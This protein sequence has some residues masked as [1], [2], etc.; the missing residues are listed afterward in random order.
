MNKFRNEYN[1]KI[2]LPQCPSCKKN[3]YCNTLYK[4]V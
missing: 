2:S 3:M 4:D 1:N